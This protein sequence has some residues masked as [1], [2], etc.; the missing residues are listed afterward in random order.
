MVKTYTPYYELELDNEFAPKRCFFCGSTA[1]S[2]VVTDSVD[3]ITIQKD[4]ICQ[5]RQCKGRTIASFAFGSWEYDLPNN[6][7]SVYPD[8]GLA[9]DEPELMI[10]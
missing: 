9:V 6:S 7:F 4:V 3:G 5:G 2:H 10:V 8:P 1:L